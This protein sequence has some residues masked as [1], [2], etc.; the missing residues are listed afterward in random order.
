MFYAPEQI[1][2]AFILLHKGKNRLRLLGVPR[3]MRRITEGLLCHVMNFT[4]DHLGEP[5]GVGGTDGGSV[6]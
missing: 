6:L 3:I 4:S 1:T 2:Q 5:C